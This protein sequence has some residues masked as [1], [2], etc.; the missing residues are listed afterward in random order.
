[1]AA[2]LKDEVEAMLAALMAA[3]HVATMTF[4]R[5]LNHV[6]NIP[7]HDSAERALN[8]LARTSA[9]RS[10]RLTAILVTASES[11]G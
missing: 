2:A 6:E 7:Q 8:R 10:R 3:V 9:L 5:R 4:A 11:H 1:V